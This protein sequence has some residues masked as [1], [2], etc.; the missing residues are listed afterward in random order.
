ML[1]LSDTGYVDGPVSIFTH[2]LLT[3]PLFTTAAARTIDR[4]SCSTTPALRKG[5][6]ERLVTD[7]IALRTLQVLVLYTEREK[8]ISEPLLCGKLS[9]NSE[10]S[11]HANAK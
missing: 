8:V 5:N 2:G 11:M 1:Y 3:R 10:A 6:T 4:A 9:Q 7:N